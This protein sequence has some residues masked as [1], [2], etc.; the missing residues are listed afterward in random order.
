[1]SNARVT[2]RQGNGPAFSAYSSATTSFPVST[3]TKIGFQTKDF[4]TNTCFDTPTSRFTPNQPGYY[5]VTAMFGV[6]SSSAAAY[7]QVVI[8]KNGT[9]V[10]TSPVSGGLGIYVNSV[11]A[12][13]YC[14]GTTDY[15]EAF[16]SQS[17]ASTQVNITGSTYRFTGCMVRGA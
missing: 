15:I 6:T 13:V 12:L 2:A 1:M 9:A 16:G 8:Y 14:N 17:T 3:L 10:Q 5:L 7:M 11:T 4:D